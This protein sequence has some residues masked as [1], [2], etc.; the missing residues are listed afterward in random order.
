[1]AITLNAIELRV[2]GVL[3]EKSLAQPAYYPMTLNALTAACNQK[4]NREPIM[5]LTDA[6]AAAGLHSL[7]QWQL[8]DQAD[9]ERGSRTNRFRHAIESRFGWNAAERAIMAE[10]M[11]RGPQTLGEL[12]TRASRMTHL[13]STDYAAELLGELARNDPPLVVELP[14]QPGRNTTRWAQLLGEE[15]PAESQPI[16]TPQPPATATAPAAQ[17]PADAQI[18]PTIETRLG[19]LEQEVIALRLDLDALRGKLGE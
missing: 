14:R 16:T 13:Q 19:S 7:Q 1:M 10:L 3:I 18:A 8:A 9:P 6:E 15:P 2:L 17:Q 11:L 5:Q 12:R 4:S